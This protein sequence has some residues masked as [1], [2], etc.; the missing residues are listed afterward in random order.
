MKA[1]PRLCIDKTLLA[2]ANLSLTA[3][4]LFAQL[5][6]HRNKRTG[7]CNPTREK[8]AEELGVSVATI[9]RAVKELSDANLIRSKKLQYTNSYEIQP[10]QNDP[11]ERSAGS[12]PTGSPGQD[13]PAAPPV[14]LY[15]PIYGEPI[16]AAYSE[17]EGVRAAAARKSIE[18]P[19]PKPPARAT[20]DP[21]FLVVREALYALAPLVR[22]TL[23]DDELVWRVIEAARGAP[24]DD[25]AAALVALYKSDQLRNMRSW[26]LILLKIGDC[27]R[28]AT[29]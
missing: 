22:L 3:R 9:K 20:S 13:D 28:R 26:G 23:P 5:L 19:T 6:D 12:N 15:E 21:V 4:I 29:A 7:Q 17:V 25:I 27:A 24:G 1:R 16:A 10:G 14:S 8:L 2:N 18:K 11:V